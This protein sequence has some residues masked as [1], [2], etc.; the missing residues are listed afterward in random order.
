MS[1]RTATL[2]AIERL[3][4]EQGYPPSVRELCEAVGRTSPATVHW[5]LEHLR[6]DGLIVSNPGQPRTLTV[7]KA[8]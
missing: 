4:A 7:V 8:A 2:Q 1:T 6:R 5:H 3:S